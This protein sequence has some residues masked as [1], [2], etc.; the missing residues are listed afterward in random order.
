LTTVRILLVALSEE[1][2]EHEVELAADP[3]VM[4]YLGHGRAPNRAEVEVKHRGRLAAALRFPVS[5]TGP[6]S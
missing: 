1:H 4:R 6:A 5:A 2:L 3:E